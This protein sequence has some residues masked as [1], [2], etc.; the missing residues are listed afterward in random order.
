MADVHKLSNQMID[1]AERLSN[2]ADA[3]AGKRMTKTTSGWSGWVILPAV[4]AGIYA[5]V[6]S[7]FVSQQAKGVVDE[8]KARASDL[9]NDLMKSVRR[10][11]QNQ[12]SGRNAT[13]QKSSSRNT[14]TR[15][16]GS[17]GRSRPRRS[18]SARKT[19]AGR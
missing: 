4:G 13:T 10:A 7:D 1:V 12:S 15:T 9:P 3:A 11:T 16:R 14:G 19:T 6:R 2:V 8:A 18:T 5:L 17:S